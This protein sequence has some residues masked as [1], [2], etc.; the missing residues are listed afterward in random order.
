MPMARYSL[1][2]LTVPLNTNNTNKQLICVYIQLSL[3]YGWAIEND[4]LNWKLLS[5]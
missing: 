1:F 2:V 5:K 3:L 4:E